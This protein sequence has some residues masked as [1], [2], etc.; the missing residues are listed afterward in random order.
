MSEKRDVGAVARSVAQVVREYVSKA[1]DALPPR[2]KRLEDSFAELSAR[3]PEKGEKGEPGRDGQN[4]VNGKDGKDGIDGRDGLLGPVGPQGE[5]GLPGESIQGPKGEI[6]ERGAD[7]KDGRDMSPADVEDMFQRHFSSWELAFDRRA[8]E[9]FERAIERMPKPKD[10]KDGFGLDD[11]SLEHDGSGNVTFRFKRGEFERTF[12]LRFPV[13]QYEGI[14]E[15]GRSYRQGN[16][17]TFGGS[18]WIALTD[19]ATEKPGTGTQWQLAVKK[20]RDGRDG[21]APPPAGPVKL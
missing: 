20:G 7:G 3:Q 10:G 13:F 5:R 16:G 18:I 4:G 12:N 14:F 6:G 8:Q 9:R 15:S 11:L 21:V 1:V 2:L 17:V 19:D